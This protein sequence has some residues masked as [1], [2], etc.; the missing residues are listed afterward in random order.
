MES[1]FMTCC[2][3]GAER[4]RKVGGGCGRLWRDATRTKGMRVRG[5][6]MAA[7]AVQGGGDRMHGCRARVRRACRCAARNIGR[8]RGREA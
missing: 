5:S 4:R 1:K 2:Q 8:A 6:T 3:G 7:W